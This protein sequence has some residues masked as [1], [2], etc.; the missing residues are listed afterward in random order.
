MKTWIFE[1][2]HHYDHQI[3]T[4]ELQTVDIGRAY[5]SWLKTCPEETLLRVGVLAG[6]ESYAKWFW[7]SKE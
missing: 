4:C 3:R 2:L 6:G 7:Q 1:F 5:D